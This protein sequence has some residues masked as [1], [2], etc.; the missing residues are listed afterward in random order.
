MNGAPPPVRGMV[1]QRCSKC[2][3]TFG[4]PIGAV[5][6]CYNCGTVN[7]ASEIE[8]LARELG[9]FQKQRDVFDAL[10]KLIAGE[11]A[12]HSKSVL[13]RLAYRIGADPEDVIAFMRHA[14]PLPKAELEQ[15]RGW[16]ARG[17][18]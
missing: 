8:A 2:R 14:K 16:M 17:P 18:K 5:P 12:V 10:H 1:D 13:R 4:Y 7:E 6:R 11:Q 3:R 15:V 9:E